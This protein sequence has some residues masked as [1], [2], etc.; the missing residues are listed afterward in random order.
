M[1]KKIV[2][3]CSQYEWYNKYYR[4]FQFLNLV[5]ILPYSQNQ[6]TTDFIMGELL[7]RV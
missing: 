4:L 1:D 7:C 5:R 6:Q 2:E 3:Y